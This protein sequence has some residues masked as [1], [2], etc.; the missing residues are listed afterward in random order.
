MSQ[1]HK[2]LKAHTKYSI[3]LAIIRLTLMN[4]QR[5]LT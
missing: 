1:A 2:E 4:I 3:M 5:F